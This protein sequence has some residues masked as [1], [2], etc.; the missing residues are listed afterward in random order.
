MTRTPTTWLLRAADAIALVALVASLAVVGHRLTASPDSSG[1]PTRAAAT[2]AA[3]AK[4][5]DRDGDGVPDSQ[6]L[7]PDTPAPASSG[8]TDEP[9]FSRPPVS[10]DCRRK[11]I[12]RSRGKEGLCMEDSGRSVRVVNRR[13][14]L[15]V[16]ELG[17]RIV[18][19]K[20]VDKPSDPWA[21]VTFDLAVQNRL[22]Y[23][24]DVQALQFRIL[25]GR[26]SYSPD[27]LAGHS[28]NSLF[29]RGTGLKPGR[30]ARGSVTFSVT[31]R[32][33]KKLAVDGN[34]EVLQFDDTSFDSAALTVGVFRTYR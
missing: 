34:V 24:A 20:V 15:R 26:G 33:I 27:L 16:E 7:A 4:S 30:T 9:A 25:L 23:A 5:G 28:A 3:G 11:G 12:T 29:R 1:P 18:R 14:P 2:P 31:H 17:V 6:D 21:H 22:G 10:G 8:S 32:A 19:M 13:S